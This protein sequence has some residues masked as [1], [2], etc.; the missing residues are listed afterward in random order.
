M[1]DQ[2]AWRKKFGVLAPSTNSIVEPD[3]NRMGVPGVTPLFAR[4]HITDPDL[5]S[6][7]QME[8]LRVQLDENIDRAIDQVCTAEVDLDGGQVWFARSEK[9][10][11]AG[12]KGYMAAYYPATIPEKRTDFRAVLLAGRRPELYRPIVAQTL[13]PRGIPEPVWERMREPRPERR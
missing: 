9:P 11:T 3:F 4:I 10:G 1:T 12:R 5:S 7:S 2:L 13:A 6:E 8:K